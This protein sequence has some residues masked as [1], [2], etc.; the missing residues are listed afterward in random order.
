MSRWP[1][2][3]VCR[4]F[5]LL[6]LIGVTLVMGVSP[7]AAAPAP[8][9]SSGVPLLGDT[10]AEQLANRYGPIAYVRQQAEP[11]DRKG[12][13][14]LPAPVE[15]VLGDPSVALKRDAGGRSEDDP[16]IVM[17]PTARDLAGKD[18]SYYLDLPGDPRAPGCTYEQ[19][20]KA[21]MAGRQPTTYAHIVPEPEHHRLTIQYWFYTYFDDFNNTHE[22]DW[23]FIQLR[24]NADSV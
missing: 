7:V 8:S 10:A 13:A 18:T 2:S 3:A 4:S 20:A 14:Y 21:R 1:S 19:D 9:T 22:S 24:F 16:V 6:A 12:E 15:L 23:E 11:C 5:C 17:G